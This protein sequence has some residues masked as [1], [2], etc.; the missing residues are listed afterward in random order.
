M[1]ATRG[2]SLCLT[3]RTYCKHAQF[4]RMKSRVECREREGTEE[5][6]APRV[7]LIQLLQRGGVDSKVPCVDSLVL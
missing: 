1:S 4:N 5:G 7:E 3:P 6:L 2:H